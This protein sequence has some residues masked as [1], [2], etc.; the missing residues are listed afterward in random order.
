MTQSKPL[1]YEQVLNVLNGFTADGVIL[2]KD[3]FPHDPTADVEHIG[4]TARCLDI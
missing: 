2:Q 4:E 1:P 3:G